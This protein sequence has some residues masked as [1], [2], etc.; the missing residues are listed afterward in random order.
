[1]DLDDVNSPTWNVGAGCCGPDVGFTAD[2]TQLSIGSGH[3]LVT[4]PLEFATCLHESTYTN[5]AIERGS[6][7]P[8]ETLCVRT[9]GRRLALI[10]IIDTSGQAID[11]GATVWDPPLP[12]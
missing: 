7:Q 11:F 3:T 10:T 6:L 2:A 5:S 1:V 12:S 4:G 8:G 9:N